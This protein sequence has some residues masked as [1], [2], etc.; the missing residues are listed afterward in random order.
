MPEPQYTADSIQ[1]LKGRDAVRKRPGMYIG[2]TDDGSG[3]HHMCFEVVD[4]AVDE[5]QAGA[6]DFV[7]VVIHDDGHVSVFDNGR[8]IPTEIH[9]EQ[10]VSAATVVM[11][12]LHA[13]GKFDGASYA[14]SGGLHGV[15]VSVVNFLSAWLEMEIYR[16]GKAH[17]Q[18]FDQGVPVGELKVVGPTTR[19]GTLVH[20]M[21][22]PAVFGSLEWVFATL[23]GR[24]RQLAY[25]N[26]GLVIKLQDQRAGQEQK[27]VYQ[28]PEGIRSFI[29]Q[30]NRTRTPLNKTAFYV[31]EERP[32]SPEEPPIVVEACL[33]WSDAYQENVFCF[34]NSIRNVDGGT[35]QAGLRAALTRTIN[36]YATEHNLAKQLKDPLSGDDVR[37]G[38]SAVLAVKVRDP[39]FSSQTKDKLVSSEVKP[40]V[41]AV[42]AERLAEFLEENPHEARAIVEKCVEAAR[43]RVAARKA[44]E[45]V[46][47]KGAL[48]NT[49]LPGKLAD[50][51]ER[52]P[53]QAELYIVEGDSAGGSAKQGRDRRTQAILPIRGKILNVEKAR[54]EK[55]LSNQEIA[56]LITA[57]GTGIDADFDIGRLRYHRVILMTDAD[58]DGSHIRTLLLT[59]FYRHMEELVNRKHLHIAQP[60]LY[61]VKRGKTSLYLKNDA[62]FDEYL[63]DAG[64]A[65]VRLV[66]PGGDVVAV[67][68]DLKALVRTMQRYL[69][70]CARLGLRYDPSVVDALARLEPLRPANL[71]DREAVEAGA[72]ALGAWLLEHAEALAPVEVRVVEDEE[73]GFSVLVGTRRDGSR[74]F[75]RIDSDLLTSGDYLELCRIQ[76]ELGELRDG[77]FE[78]EI[79]GRDE[80]VPAEGLEA[81]AEAVVAN[82]RKGL[83]IQRYKGLGEMNPE[84]LWDTTMNPS[85]RTMLQ[86]HPG[87]DIETDEIFT[88]LMGDDVERRRHFIEEHALEVR[89]LDV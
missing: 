2:D 37:E 24:M 60:P 59:F 6:A 13:G 84:Q 39:K 73:E 34:T 68:E 40:V 56:A 29:E 64:A 85:T 65:G 46:R 10:G 27:V 86:V 51:Q 5:A 19:Q 77:A 71:V 61:R 7:K 36:A 22:D 25:L 88:I 9:A 80:P 31:L 23:S 87:E 54:L 12:E 69:G 11:T 82:G 50:C 44:R 16:Q 1:V 20:F 26:A 35:H 81:V 89:N 33:Q 83:S 53:S 78:L 58:V 62:A 43:A 42:V 52:D 18:R 38:L 55:V 4:N 28:Y 63:R 49:S 75:T 76:R 17:F 15:G 70:I 67:G 32:P 79:D 41:E 8:G 72:E 66:R 47:R 48:E 74:R 30:L 57:L 14:Y 45:L 21:P 3:L